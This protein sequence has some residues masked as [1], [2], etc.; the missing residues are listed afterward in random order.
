MSPQQIQ[1]KRES[2]EAMQG[3][4]YL[5][6]LPGLRLYLESRWLSTGLGWT[7][8]AEAKVVGKGV[9]NLDKKLTDFQQLKTFQLLRMHK[10]NVLN[11]C[12]TSRVPRLCNGGGKYKSNAL[13]GPNAFLRRQ[14][15]WG[16]GLRFCPRHDPLTVG[17]GHGHEMASRRLP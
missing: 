14:E 15:L 17:Q 3:K 8:S 2:R 12:L 7:S 10:L 5:S 13:F 1:L 6:C 11:V 16:S 4:A 9:V